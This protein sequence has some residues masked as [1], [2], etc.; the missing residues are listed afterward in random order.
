M[1]G[2]SA[3]VG[4][5]GLDD[6]RSLRLFDP[7]AQ[8][9]SS[10][11]YQIGQ[12]WKLELRQKASIR[13]PHI[14][15]VLVASRRFIR[16]DPNPH[17]TI[18]DRVEPWEVPLELVFEGTLQEANGKLYV[19]PNGSCPSCST[20]FWI[21]DRRLVLVGSRYT[22]DEAPY[23]SIKYV[24]LDAP[25][26]QIQPGELVRLSLASWFQGEHFSEERCYLQVSGSFS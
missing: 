3:C 1:G 14:E 6:G 15:D 26:T 19:G 8:Y 18:L 5:L 9:P 16:V 4:A 11:D 24:G 23:L 2:T 21:A 22:T 10:N 12:V 25:P 7:V 20:G 17:S 13:P